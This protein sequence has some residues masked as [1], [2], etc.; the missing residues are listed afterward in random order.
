MK[1]IGL[2]A[3]LAAL[4]WPGTTQKCAIRGLVSRVL[5]R[6]LSARAE[7]CS[8]GDTAKSSGQTSISSQIRINR[9]FCKTN[10]RRCWTLYDPAT[11]YEF[12]GGPTPTL[13]SECWDTS[14]TLLE[15]ASHADDDVDFVGVVDVERVVDGCRRPQKRRFHVTALQGG[16]RSE[17]PRCHRGRV[18]RYRRHA[19]LRQPRSRRRPEVLPPQR[20]LTGTDVG[21][22]HRIC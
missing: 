3:P 16:T 2:V 9:G 7:L 13:D 8:E 5:E 4:Q 19:V 6:S 15:S 17:H 10:R 21:Q 11:T 1:T 20:R 12:P 22:G 18:H 14:P